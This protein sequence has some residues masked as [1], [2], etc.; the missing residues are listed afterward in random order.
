MQGGGRPREPP[1]EGGDALAHASAAITFR[2]AFGRCLPV[3][4]EG[5][6]GARAGPAGT[7]RAERSQASTGLCLPPP[8]FSSRPGPGAGPGGAVRPRRAGGMAML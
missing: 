3:S 8:P 6:T 2:M 4:D 5:I 7:S 1:G